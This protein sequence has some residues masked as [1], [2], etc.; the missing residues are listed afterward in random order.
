MTADFSNTASKSAE[1]SAPLSR[2][3]MAT[4]AILMET[5]A[6]KPGNVHRGSDF[7]YVTFFDFAAGAVAIAPAI[8]SAASGARL[9]RVVYDAIAATRCEV[10]IN[11]NLGTVLLLAPLAL[12]AD[13]ERLAEGVPRVLAGLNAEDAQLVYAAI[14][15][16]QP[17][18]MGKVEEHDLAGQP[19]A[20]LLVAMQAAADRDL[21]A[22]QYVNN[23]AQVF[24]TVIPALCAGLARGWGLCDTIVRTHVELL[25]KY[26]DSLIARKCGAKI[27]AESAVRAQR[28]LDAGE[29]GDEN[30]LLE[31][32]ELDFWLRSDHHRRN[33]GTTADLIAAGLFAALREG[34]IKPPYRWSAL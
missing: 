5:S 4:L 30:Y 7:E 1:N 25:A 33:P 23:F 14:G 3:Q 17:G 22:R 8:E 20:D 16:A 29:P 6:P 12:V 15:L 24:E 19:P 11:T 18:G 27:A 10:D 2:G 21:V 32:S 31:L 28:T 13:G 26:P 9:G 34:I